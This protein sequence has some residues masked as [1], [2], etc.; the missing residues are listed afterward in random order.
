MGFDRPYQLHK[1]IIPV[2]F[3]EQTKIEAMDRLVTDSFGPIDSR[4]EQID[5]AFTHYYDAEL[6][7]PIF[8]VLYSLA[9]L[10]NPTDLARFKHLSNDIEA[11]TARP[12]GRRT[13]NLDPG[14][15][16]LS[17]VI[18]ATTKPSA[19]RIPI[20]LSMHAEIT[21]LYRRGR[22]QALEWTYLDFSSHAYD[23]WFLSVRRRYHEQLKT[24]DPEINWRL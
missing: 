5:F 15:L 21:L 19:H 9:E 13:I 23:D 18:L 12:D 22:F 17:R 11:Q 14:L 6:G 2:L 8:R 3:T 24:L 7:T 4:S 1:L 16:S 20:G 10:V